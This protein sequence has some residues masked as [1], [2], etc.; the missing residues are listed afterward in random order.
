[1]NIF[2]TSVFDSEV[3]FLSLSQKQWEPD[4]RSGHISVSFLS[5]EVCENEHVFAWLLGKTLDAAVSNWSWAL[6]VIHLK[7]LFTVFHWTSLTHDSERA[8]EQELRVPPAFS[9]AFSPWTLIFRRGS[10]SLAERWRKVTR[11]CGPSSQCGQNWCYLFS[12]WVLEMLRYSRRSMGE[13]PPWMR[14]LAVDVMIFVVVPPA[15]PPPADSAFT[16]AL[17]QGVHGGVSAFWQR[18]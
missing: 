1:M 16:P 12:V 4:P 2:D 9:P 6:S 13:G 7:A 18:N 8:L 17:L 15:P 11:G 14:H 10:Q 5:E 3:S